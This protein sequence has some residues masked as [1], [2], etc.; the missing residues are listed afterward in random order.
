M[1]QIVELMRKYI[2]VAVIN[3]SKVLRKKMAIMNEQMD[4]KEILSEK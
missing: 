4:W 1:T 2:K 3:M